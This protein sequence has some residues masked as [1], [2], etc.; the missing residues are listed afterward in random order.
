MWILYYC[1]VVCALS[2]LLIG[3]CLVYDAVTKTPTECAPG[4]YACAAGQCTADP[5][6]S[7]VDLASCL[8][9]CDR[10]QCVTTSSVA[11]CVVSPGNLG[12]GT[13]A[14]CR[15]AC[16]T[17]PAPMYVCDAAL[18]CRPALA[19]EP[20]KYTDRTCNSKCTTCDLNSD[21]MCDTVLLDPDTQPKY[22]DW[23][24]CE[25]A[26]YTYSCASYQDSVCARDKAKIAG[27]A[28]NPTD[29]AKTCNPDKYPACKGGFGPS[30]NMTGTPLTTGD[31]CAGKDAGDTCSYTV[32]GVDLDGVCVRCATDDGITEPYCMVGST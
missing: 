13:M 30:T 28:A 24:A 6:G 1:M 4:K 21:G 9:Y 20:G 31:M 16:G 12:L 26:N 3:G 15:A 29:C 10:A 17:E 5:D 19:D 18:G 23:S 22:P 27:H 7:F 32:Y 25:A 11:E 14:Q 2:I 8:G